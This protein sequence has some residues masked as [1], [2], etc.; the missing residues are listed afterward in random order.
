MTGMPYVKKVGSCIIL[1]GLRR[2]SLMECKP[3]KRQQYQLENRKLTLD[4]L[5]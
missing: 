3:F 5:H 1:Y 4:S 2:N